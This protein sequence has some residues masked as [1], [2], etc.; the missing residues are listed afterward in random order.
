MV[1]ISNVCLYSIIKV[2]D[3]GNTG[4]VDCQLSSVAGGNSVVHTKAA[5]IDRKKIRT[6]FLS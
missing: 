6:I 2:W 3:S 1:I 5:A 4:T